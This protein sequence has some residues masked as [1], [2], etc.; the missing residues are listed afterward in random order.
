VEG[1]G[2]QVAEEEE[3][4]EGGGAEE[5]GLLKTMKEGEARAIKEEQARAARKGVTGCG[6]WSLLPR[7]TVFSRPSP[8]EVLGV[9]L[10]VK[11]LEFRVWANRQRFR[12]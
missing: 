3:E 1:G 2:G 7:S 8:P 11:G 5:E 6:S 12:V 4:E 9:G 10:R